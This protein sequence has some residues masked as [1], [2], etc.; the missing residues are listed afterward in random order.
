MGIQ[1]RKE[2]ARLRER[3]TERAK[4][5]V[6]VEAGNGYTR[7]RGESAI[8]REKRE[9]DCESECIFDSRSSSCNLPI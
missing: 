4:E 5:C 7:E 9:R 3:R 6:Y 1:E 2:R 8:A